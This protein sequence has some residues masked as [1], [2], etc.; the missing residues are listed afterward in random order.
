MFHEK[1]WMLAAYVG[2][3]FV[4]KQWVSEWDEKWALAYVLVS[5]GFKI[6]S[7]WYSYFYVFR[8]D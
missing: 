1:C 2:K 8:I 3:N 5:L 6:I 4:D 7:V